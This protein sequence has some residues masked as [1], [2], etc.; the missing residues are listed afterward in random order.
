V[1]I[2]RVRSY[3]GSTGNE[4]NGTEPAVKSSGNRLAG[5]R[6]LVTGAANGIGRAIAMRFVA[7]GAVVAGVDID[8]PG[9]ERTKTELSTYGD[10]F[11][12]A[13]GDVTRLAVVEQTVPKAVAAM[14]GLDI[15]VN[16]VGLSA[17]GTVETTSEA[18]WDRVALNTKSIF[19]VSKFTVPYLRAA[20]GG[21]I[22]NIGS[23][24]GIHPETNRVAYGT[25]KAA[26]VMMTK[27]MALDH[28]PDAIRVNCVSPGVTETALSQGNRRREAQRRGITLEDVNREI[29][30]TYPLGRTGDMFDIANGVLYLASDEARW[31]TGASLVIDGGWSAGEYRLK[32]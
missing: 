24:T 27:F 15:V 7:E 18:D 31:V 5:K 4:A 23:C 21:A 19:L 29:I 11:I 22:I 26:V 16:N 14:G 17:R 1:D 9:L 20:G 6:A 25:A 28:G 10:D 12:C 13:A 30:S 8:S 3:G 32:T 2:P